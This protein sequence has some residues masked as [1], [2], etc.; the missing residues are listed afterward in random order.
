M[1]R[2]FDG[3][4]DVELIAPL[5]DVGYITEYFALFLELKILCLGRSCFGAVLH[6]NIMQYYFI[7]PID[8]TSYKF[9][10]SFNLLKHHRRSS[11]HQ[12]SSLYLHRI[13]PKLFSSS[14]LIS[15]S[16]SLS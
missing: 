8:N 9:Y 2:Y 7:A 3:R 10:Y 14:L 11:F 13:I 16:T 15:Y 12:L 1:K 6:L 5:A 4:G